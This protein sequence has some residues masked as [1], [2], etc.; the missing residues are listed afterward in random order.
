MATAN[1]KKKTVQPLL[2]CEIVKK[3]PG[4]EQVDLGVRIE[5]PGHWFNAIPAEDRNKRFVSTAVEYQAC[6]PFYGNNRSLAKTEAIQF[7]VEE[8]VVDDPEHEGYWIRLNVWDRY[9]HDTFKDNRE[10]ELQY[11]R[12][13]Q[14]SQLV[15]QDT[16]AIA[17]EN[18][19]KRSGKAPVYLYFD[20]V[21]SGTHI[22]AKG[23]N[24]GKVSKCEL[25]K[26]KLCVSSSDD[27]FKAL[28]KHVEF[29]LFVVVD[30]K[31]FQLSRSEPFRQFCLASE[32]PLC[33]LLSGQFE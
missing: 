22:I 7:Q 20:F 19:D 10:A 27:V 33:A 18:A 23:P 4:Q 21:G 31:H 24:K 5:I 3:Y 13:A 28:P 12:N 32:Q 1:S 6:R 8:D 29:V 26:C 9:R 17:D 14:P 11:V 25:W 30:L 16:A 15:A 2:P